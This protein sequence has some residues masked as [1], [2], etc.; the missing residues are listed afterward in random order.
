ML[1]RM[2][3]AGMLP[4][5]VIVCL[6]TPQAAS[7]TILKKKRSAAIGRMFGRSYGEIQRA[8]QDLFPLQ[9]AMDRWGI[10]RAAQHQQEHG[11]AAHRKKRVDLHSMDANDLE[12]VMGWLREESTTY[13]ASGCGNLQEKLRR[14]TGRTI[15]QSTIDD[16]VR[17][18]NVTVKRT[19]FVHPLRDPVQ[20]AQTR[21][22]VRSYPLK[23]VMC[24]DASHFDNRTHL[25]RR[26]RAP[27]GA[28][29]RSSTTAMPGSGLRSLYAAM[30]ISGMVISACTIIDGAIDTEM[31]MSWVYTDLVPVLRPYDPSNPMPNSVLLLDNAGIHRT[32]EFL[33]LLDSMDVKY[34]FLTPYDPRCQP[35][36]RAFHQVWCMRL[37]A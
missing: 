33:R 35:I 26:G 11:D 24:I 22:D 25:R 6:L 3:A 8:Q 14:A 2:L 21:I 30:N 12:L 20:S 9:G 16:A 10:R 31:F 28:P 1:R 5:L 37:N 7:S 4:V 36:E 23:C 13:T 32:P 15:S 19:E 34:I 17:A 18:A 29:A 27:K